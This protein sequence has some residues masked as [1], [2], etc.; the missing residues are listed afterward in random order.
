MSITGKLYCGMIISA[1]NNLD[2]N[3]ED[4]NNLNV[5]PVPD[6][7]TGTNMSLTMTYLGRRYRQAAQTLFVNILKVYSGLKQETVDCLTL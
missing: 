7:D 3:K 5:F 2:N 1:A 6:G 4:T